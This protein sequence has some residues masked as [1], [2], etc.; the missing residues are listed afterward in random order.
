MIGIGDHELS[1]PRRLDHLDTPVVGLLCDPRGRFVVSRSEDGQI[2]IRDLG[3]D[4][5]PRVVEGP[6]VNLDCGSGGDRITAWG[7]TRGKDNVET[8][9]WSLLKMRCRRCFATSISEKAAELQAGRSI[10][11]KARSSASSTPTR[12]SGSG[13]CGRLPMPSPPSFNEA[14]TALQ[15]AWRFTRRVAGWRVRLQIV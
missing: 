4:S 2:R 13:R 5:R 10:Q 6:A 15:D 11:L 8:W 1:E 7:S 9:I 12:R 14:T 3:G